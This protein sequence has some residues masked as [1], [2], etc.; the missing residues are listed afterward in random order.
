MGR[1]FQNEQFVTVQQKGKGNGGK[2]YELP[3]EKL[4]EQSCNACSIVRDDLHN[5][6]MKPAGA[7]RPDVYVL[8]EAPGR[9]ED[10]R[11]IPFVG[12][13]GEY[14]RA[15]LPDHWSIRY[16]NVLQCRPEGNRD[17]T[18]KEMEC[19][20]S[21]VVGDIV[22]RKP[23]VI[24]GTGAVPLR[25]LL[26]VN[27]NYSITA[28]RGRFLPVRIGDHECWYVPLFHPSYLRRKQKRNNF[29]GE[30]E[31]SIEGVAFQYDL[32]QVDKLLDDYVP[33]VV[34]ERSDHGIHW[35][36]GN[37]KRDL[38]R[39]RRW[40]QHLRKLPRVAV[41]VETKNLRPYHNNSRLLTIA[42]GTYD[43]TYAFPIEH[44]AGWG[45]RYQQIIHDEVREFLLQSGTKICHNLNME[46]EWFAHY[47][48]DDILRRTEWADTHAQAYVL[49][50]RKG[51][52]NLDV[53][54]ILRLGINDFKPDDLPMDRL[55]TVPLSRVLPYNALDTKYT[56]ELDKVQ[57]AEL[58]RPG[59]EKLVEVY[60]RHI[61]RNPAI[62]LM[63][64]AGMIV[65][66]ELAQDMRNRFN[67]R[68]KELWNQMR[69]LPEVKRAER[70][71]GNKPYDPYKAAHN[72]VLYDEVLG[73]KECWVSEHGEE[74][75]QKRFTLNKSVLAQIPPSV[76]R[77]P[78]LLAEYRSTR[79][80]VANFL[81]SLGRRL[82]PDGK[83]HP[84]VNDKFTSTGRLS[85]DNPNGQNFPKQRLPEV[86]Q[87]IIAPSG[88]WLLAVDYGAI[89]Y[90]AIAM[91]S[92]D[93]K[94]H[95]LLWSGQDIHR[96]WAHRFIELMGKPAIQRSTMHYYGFNSR[97]QL[98]K[99]DK[100][101]DQ[102]RQMMKNR[103]VFP[104]FFGASDKA[105]AGYMNIGLDDARRVGK[106]FWEEYK[107]VKAWQRELDVELRDL[108]RGYIETLTG[109]R[110][111]IPLTRTEMVDTPVQGTAAEIVNDAM[112]RLSEAGY[113]A[114]L[115]V[116]DEL[117]FRLPA[118]TFDSDAMEIIRM[119]AQPAFDFITVPLVVEAKAGPN[120]Y[121]TELIGEFSS[122]EFGHK[123][124]K[125]PRRRDRLARQA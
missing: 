31:E 24:L 58:H 87:I 46:Q 35:V 76:T 71:L 88:Q 61:R 22:R 118:K 75:G 121:Q 34:Y 28:W 16:G 8:G 125:R 117:L 12:W 11:G 49:D 100:F 79:V 43:E 63:Q 59:N 89:E 40:L 60:D 1:F 70:R 103:W 21:R 74:E 47:Y 15:R 19:C 26:N 5:P 104:K 92:K 50:E 27:G 32:R 14:L 94:I 56:F 33:P 97:R 105:C 85:M 20:R 112:T 10:E 93:P 57:L 91:L 55:D 62:V 7:R 45:K 113:Q 44:P 17:P 123:Q 64:R 101:I 95:E 29:T 111:R 2:T 36:E 30:I 108:D 115:N 37:S 102:A 106:I 84:N 38:Q 53:L 18:P 13:A 23:K 54:M 114:H 41:D 116:H 110:R 67:A 4:R 90:R 65:D 83:L 68:L 122:T 120:W 42:I 78:Q 77:H 51:M 86:R 48:G 39:I 72:K 66:Q 73:R 6:Y 69:A 99:G 82:C 80:V 25:W 3:V 96:E 52:H 109:R 81:E 124:Q 98:N 107:G 119:M 9:T